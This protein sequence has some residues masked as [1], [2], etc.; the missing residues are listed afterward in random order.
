MIDS[1]A[2]ALHCGRVLALTRGNTGK[3]RKL[4]F[5]DSMAFEDKATV[6]RRNLSATDRQ[7]AIRTERLGAEI[8]KLAERARRLRAK[9][10]NCYVKIK[11]Y[12]VSAATE[13][14]KNPELK[15]RTRRRQRKARGQV[16]T[17]RS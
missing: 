14:K 4:F 15:K 5:S 12:T 17:R 6:L 9:L 3:I 11:R 8:E 13:E 7:Q 1:G 16:V 2:T 10:E